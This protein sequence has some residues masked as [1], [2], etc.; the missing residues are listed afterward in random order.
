MF[1]RDENSLFKFKCA[2]VANC[3]LNNPVK[4]D[5]LS[6]PHERKLK[7]LRGRGDE[8]KKDDLGHSAIGID[9]GAHQ[10]DI[11]LTFLFKSPH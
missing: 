7:V 10:D 8:N 2:R 3:I 9:L 11:F 5:A 6:K 1:V 4:A